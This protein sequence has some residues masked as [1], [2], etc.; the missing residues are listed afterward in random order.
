[1]SAY[2]DLPWE[3]AGNESNEQARDARKA[4][5][6]ALHV[7]IL[8]PRRRVIPLNHPLLTRAQYDTLMAH[9]DAHQD[10]TFDYSRTRGG[11]LETF[12]VR[13]AEPPQDK[14][15]RG[16]RFDVTVTLVEA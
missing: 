2:P 6:G 15:V 10:I 12:T 5:N 13:Y 16:L 4:T 11:V 14:Y 8:G 9:Y 7:R 3:Y 1:M